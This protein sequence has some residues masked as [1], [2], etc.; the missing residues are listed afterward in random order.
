MTLRINIHPSPEI[1][2]FDIHLPYVAAPFRNQ[3]KKARHGQQVWVQNLLLAIGDAKKI[4]LC[5]NGDPQSRLDMTRLAIAKYAPNIEVEIEKSLNPDRY[6]H[7][8]LLFSN[9]SSYAVVPNQLDK[10]SVKEAL[11][12]YLENFN[13]FEIS[14][15]RINDRDHGYFPYNNMMWY[16]F[17]KAMPETNNQ[18][19]IIMNRMLANIWKEIN[20]ICYK[21]FEDFNIPKCQVEDNLN[22]RIVH[23]K[24]NDTPDDGYQFFKHVDGSLITGWLYEIT[25]GAKIGIWKDC[26]QS[27]PE[28]KM[29]PIQ[30]L[31]NQDSKDL[32]LI[33]GLA[34]CDYND[35]STSATWHEVQIE[36]DFKNHRVSMVFMLRAPSFEKTNY[37]FDNL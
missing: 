25:A 2:N 5:N 14:S 33:P 8:D 27:E 28:T 24:P 22:V 36:D 34:W 6:Q 11:N 12:F 30:N 21:L 19:N 32:L 37:H 1:K 3:S 26:L 10:H 29:V 18:Y 4:C 15:I 17:G 20:N 13:Q 9:H 31:Y 16:T 35:N 7:P 23:N